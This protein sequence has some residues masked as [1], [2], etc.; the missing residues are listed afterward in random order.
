MSLL[1]QIG[2]VVTL[3]VVIGAFTLVFC[4]C[5]M[6]GIADERI[7]AQRDANGRGEL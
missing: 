5:V 6:A 7:Q 1:L 2:I 4:A 3:L